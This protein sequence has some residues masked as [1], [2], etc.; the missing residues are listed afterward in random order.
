MR[1]IMPK[2]NI[3]DI[4]KHGE[5]FKIRKLDLNDPEVIKMINAVKKEQKKILKRKE[6]DWEKMRNT[7][8]NI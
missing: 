7:V 8:I 4:F 3:N 1:I 6:I 2:T 5:D